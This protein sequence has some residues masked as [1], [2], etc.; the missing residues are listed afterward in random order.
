MDPPTF[1]TGPTSPCC[2]SVNY[3]R[4]LR[5]Q[6]TGSRLDFSRSPVHQCTQ[7]HSS[8]AGQAEWGWYLLLSRGLGTC[9]PRRESSEALV[10]PV[11]EG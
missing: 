10:W 7:C 4:M 3:K 2:A 1:W 11:P 5:A 8:L 6:G 9:R